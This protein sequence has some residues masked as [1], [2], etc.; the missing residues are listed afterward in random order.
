M[1][2]LL[3]AVML[4]ASVPV[5][6]EASKLDIGPLLKQLSA[7]SAVT[8]KGTILGGGCYAPITWAWGGLNG[9]VLWA[10]N[11]EERGIGGGV[12]AFSIR[13]DKAWD[14][15]WNKSDLG[16]RGVEVHFVVPKVEFG[17]TGGWHQST[18][19]FYGGFLNIGWPF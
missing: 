16:S 17:P 18:G 8:H 2:G 12:A 10:A 15:V 11:G 4:S 13:A 19:W 1:K 14:W 5:Q 9:G 7:C 6:A 3:I